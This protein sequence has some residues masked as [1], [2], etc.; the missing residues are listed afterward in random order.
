MYLYGGRHVLSLS[1]RRGA[2]RVLHMLRRSIGWE[3]STIEPSIALD[4]RGVVPVGLVATT[5]SPTVPETR[6]FNQI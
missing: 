4:T 1:C 6:S 3:I 5:F 2:G